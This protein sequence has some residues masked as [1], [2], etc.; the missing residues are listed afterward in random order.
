MV[1]SEAP[2]RV[3]VQEALMGANPMSVNFD[4]GAE[5]EKWLSTVLRE[6]DVTKKLCLTTCQS[7]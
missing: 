5:E 1:G 7:M 6:N 2:Q 4:I 3:K